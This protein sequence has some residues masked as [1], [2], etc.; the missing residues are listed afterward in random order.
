MK[1]NRCEKK[2]T[3]SRKYSG[4]TLCSECFSSSIIRKTAKTISK[5]KMIKNGDLVYLEV[6][7]QWLYLQDSTFLLENLLARRSEYH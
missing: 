1:C 3:Y 4:E 7:V 2:A 6:Q 5:F